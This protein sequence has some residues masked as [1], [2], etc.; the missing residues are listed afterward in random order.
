MAELVEKIRITNEVFSITQYIR[1]VIRIICGG[2]SGANESVTDAAIKLSILD[3][4]QIL[5]RDQQTGQSRQTLVR[6]PPQA[7]LPAFYSP[8]KALLSISVPI[9]CSDRVMRNRIIQMLL[10][11]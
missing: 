9:P 8:G 3:G 5:K 7:I 6:R 11:Q 10:S 4:N 1:R 2:R